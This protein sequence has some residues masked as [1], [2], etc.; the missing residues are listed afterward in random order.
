MTR[1]P[2][3]VGFGGVNAAGR[4]AFHHGYKRMIESALPAE[5][6][7]PT[8]QNLATMMNLDT[9]GGL[10]PELIETLRAGTLIR[11]I[12]PVHFDVDAVLYQHKAD[13]HGLHGDMEF[14]ARRNQL[15][16]H[17]PENW[18]V[19]A[20]TGREVTVKVTGATPALFPEHKKYP[21][22]SAGQVPT[23]F[24]AASM[25][26][27]MH[28]PRALTQAVYG[29]SDA[30]NSLG[31]DWSEIL[32]HISPDEVSVYAGSALGQVDDKGYGGLYQTELTGGRTSSKMMALS[33]GEMAADFINS[34]MIN[35]VGSTG[36]NVG[37]CATFLYNLRQG[38]ID[39]QSGKARAVIVGNTEA[40]VNPAIMGG[41]DVMG[42]LANDDNLRRLDELPDGAPVDNRRA[43]RPFSANVGFT[44]AESAQFIIL[45]DDE[46]ALATGANIHGSVP[47]VF[48]NADANKKSISAP[49]VG[50][51]ITIAKAAALAESLLGEGGLAQTFV[52]AHGTGTPQNRVTESHILNE[53]AK[54]HG[55]N[56]WA[57][58]AVKSYVGHSLGPAAADQIIASLGVWAH[59]IIPGIKT[60][61]HIADDVHNSNL[62]IL[63]DHHDTGSL[64]AMR[65][66]VINS[67][68]FGG[69]N[70]SALILS[71]DETL[72]MMRKRHGDAAV[73][74]WQQ[75]NEPVAATAK[76]ND[77][78]A[79]KNGVPIIYKFGES[80]MDENDVKLSK[81]QI[82]LKEFA[83]SISL[84]SKHPYGD[85]TP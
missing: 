15:P 19:T 10:T 46:L 56:D 18:E 1:L 20:V 36:S 35:S 26:R 44:M 67:K 34:Y 12:E 50:N 73:A 72:K 66:S 85:M 60:I 79:I 47:D 28:H 25:Y 7:A 83:N 23:G 22:S 63:M 6:M 64:T 5:T 77:E 76:Q 62:N 84:A 8:W 51:Y 16:R 37:A 38:M 61:D 3:I 55:V 41:F 14:T 2:V 29:A 17:L 82:T 71:P 11:R 68:G 80:V 52:Q 69:N 49:G 75:R 54:L 65:G 40:P 24:D 9:S 58:T 31:M 53:V 21:V 74:A 78:N 57:V 70:A 42:A 32:K 43:C 48:I 27:S 45:M 81:E 39:I 13:I 59:G 33:L 4:S 30:L